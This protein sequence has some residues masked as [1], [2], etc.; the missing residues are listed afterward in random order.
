MDEGN[1]QA[2]VTVCHD[3]KPIETFSI[4]A[5]EEEKLTLIQALLNNVEPSDEGLYTITVEYKRQKYI[6]KIAVAVGECS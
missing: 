1:N 2:E 5:N 6:H 3:D 4:N